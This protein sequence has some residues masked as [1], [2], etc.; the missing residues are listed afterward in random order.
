[1][2]VGVFHIIIFPS[3]CQLHRPNEF[4]NL[5]FLFNYCAV[6]FYLQQS[7][8][9]SQHLGKLTQKETFPLKIPHIEMKSSTN[10]I[11]TTDWKLTPTRLVKLCIAIDIR[12]IDT[13]SIRLFHLFWLQKQCFLCWALYVLTKRA[14]T[15]DAKCPRFKSLLFEISTIKKNGGIHFQMLTIARTLHE[16]RLQVIISALWKQ[17]C[18][19]KKK[20]ENSS[21]HLFRLLCRIHFIFKF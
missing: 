3:T 13:F 8:Q 9:F 4:F 1:M 12:T 5:F 6:A 21:F 10:R 2:P 14:V 16:I 7:N 20:E 17:K 15:C 11:E 18:T 19:G